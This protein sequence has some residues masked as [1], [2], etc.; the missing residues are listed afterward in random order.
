MR[1]LHK[2]MAMALK[3]RARS[4][5]IIVSGIQQRAELYEK[6]YVH[7]KQA[8]INTVARDAAPAERYARQG[9]E[10]RKPDVDPLTPEMVAK[11]A[12]LDARHYGKL[13]DPAHRETAA[14]AMASTA[15]LSAGY[16]A[17]LAGMAP[18]IAGA[19]LT[20]MGAAEQDKVVAP[21][22]INRV[23]NDQ[24]VAEQLV[25]NCIEQV[26][27]HKRG[28][29]AGHGDG[30]RAA[31]TGADQSQ[32]KTMRAHA[33][34]NNQVASDEVF[35]ASKDDA[36]PIVP[37]DIETTYLRVGT[38]FYHPKNTQVVAFE[39]K[40]NKLETHSNSEQIATAMI[41]IARARGWDEI[42]VSG[43]ET[44]RKEAWLEAAAHG[45]HVKGY[46]PSD[47]DKA[48][49]A[50]R[51]GYV[52]AR[53]AG[54]GGKVPGAET[55]PVAVQASAAGLSGTDQLENVGKQGT[56]AKAANAANAHGVGERQ[57]RTGEGLRAQA[58]ASRP[59]AEAIVD[60]PELAGTYAALASMKKKAI[61]DGLSPQQRAVV[62]AR[63]EANLVNSIERG[64][65]PEVKVREQVE[66]RSER[67]EARERKR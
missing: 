40:G 15:R 30:E 13:H 33:P 10:P 23:G 66:L 51:T 67:T 64:Q 27:K 26:I 31:P 7:A 44:F 34:G 58:F 60:H 25:F 17:A 14:L 37:V 49:L 4:E 32:P 3:G 5:P 20:A 42:R 46:T 29:H 21:L 57:A 50:K 35:T 28:R 62:M 24:T 63:V 43:S 55:S 48:A 8:A 54:P 36:R 38:R 41:S 6:A 1:E 45:M 47:V 19:V 61:A 56:A 9:K 53:R 16:R 12:A 65:L 59:P 39:D 52:E 18:Q 22:R 2:A 11:L